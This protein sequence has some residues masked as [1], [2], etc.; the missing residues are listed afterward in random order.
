M[1][2]GTLIGDMGTILSGGQKQRV[3]IARA[4]Y[5]RPAILM[6][7][8]ATSHLD[9][10]RERGVNAAVAATDMT[11]IVIAHRPETIRACSRSIVV[12]D[13]KVACGEPDLSQ[14][15]LEFVPATIGFAEAVD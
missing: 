9:V 3:L 14:S 1:G 8:E 2:Y 13:G 10:D 12:E 4:L 7:D 6:L 11:R 15:L 5:R